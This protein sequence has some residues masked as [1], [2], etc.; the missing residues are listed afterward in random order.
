MSRKVRGK[1]QKLYLIEYD[2]INDYQKVFSVMGS[3]GNVYDVNIKNVPTCSC[4]DYTTRHKRCKHIYFILLRV[5]K[6]NSEDE[7]TK[8]YED[9]ELVYMFSKIP[10]IA[11]NVKISKTQLDK[12]KILKKSDSKTSITSKQKDMDDIC[13]ICL[14]DLTNGMKVVYCKYSCGKNIHSDCFK[15]WSKQKNKPE[16]VYCRMPW[17]NLKNAKYINIT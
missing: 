2:D 8:K 12:Y 9:G 14:D 11:K 16:C 4:P 7:D 6:V 1:T 5:M 3:T 10:N 13:P 15:M 17:N